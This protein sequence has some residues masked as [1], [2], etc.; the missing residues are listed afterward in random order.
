MAAV[1]ER[2]KRNVWNEYVPQSGEVKKIKYDLNT[3]HDA[4]YRTVLFNKKT[5][6]NAGA[7]KPGGAAGLLSPADN[8][9]APSLLP[10][11]AAP[12]NPLSPPPVG[13]A[14]AS[15]APTS[16]TS[17]PL[18]T[19]TAIPAAG[20][21]SA[22]PVAGTAASTALGLTVDPAT[23]PRRRVYVGSIHFALT[24][25]DIRACF[26]TLGKIVSTEMPKDPAT[27]RHKGYCFVE[28]STVEEADTA[29]KTMSGFELAGRP[30]RV[31][32]PHDATIN[33]SAPVSAAAEAA[34]A[35]AMAINQQISPA[36]PITNSSR[37]Y[38]G[39]IFWNIGEPELRA[40]FATF[41]EIVSVQ[42]IPNHETGKHKGY[43]FI[44][45]TSAASAEEAIKTMNGFELAGRSLRVSY[46]TGGGA[47][48]TVGG[49]GAMNAMGG[50]A[51]QQNL[52]LAG[53]IAAAAV[54]KAQQAM[55][56][57]AQSLQDEEDMEIKA[58]QR[59]ALM[60][61]L[62]AGAGLGGDMAKC[63]AI[64]NM[65]GSLND[66]DDDLQMEVK[67]ECSKFGEVEEV[68]V[69]HRQDPVKGFIG[70]VFV[71]FKT[72]QGANT[73]IPALTGR[74]FDGRRIEVGSPW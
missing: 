46:P 25:A 10:L 27:M 12:V 13:G 50:Q 29:I 44:E 3:I 16:A 17:L 58:D 42:L 68:R 11:A 41:G 39:N 52:G 15:V 9:Q 43:G 45:F 70:K 74:F 60:Q 34:K 23:R 48:A 35:A 67:Q 22:L 62:R 37:V 38:V 4:A 36:K 14:P 5:L 51:G 6:K 32:R 54:F 63:I 72:P 2:R 1:E 69:H 56:D 18:P 31:G 19:G 55:S 33:D 61:K 7:S 28:Y 59:Y 24:E 26:E 40:V 57:T 47:P 53:A 20:Q 64:S 30:I 21:G 71:L 66:I 65:L 8:G 73:A 49:G